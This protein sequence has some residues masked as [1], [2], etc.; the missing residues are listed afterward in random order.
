MIALLRPEIARIFGRRREANCSEVLS[1]RRKRWVECRRVA[2]VGAVDRRRHNDARIE[3]NRVLRFVREMRR[4]VL[5]LG[6]LRVRIGL[7]RP[8]L[9]RQPLAFALAVK[10]DEVTPNWQACSSRKTAL[11]ASQG[12][13]PVAPWISWASR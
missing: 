12:D 3:I 1:R 9:V 5:H 2:F 10:L 7:A 4:A 6:D 11:G 8:I 13:E